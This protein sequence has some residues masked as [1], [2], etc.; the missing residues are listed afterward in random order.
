MR[1]EKRD[2][3][4][5]VGAV[6]SDDIKCMNMT[7]K[8]LA[9]Q[10]GIPKSLISEIISG[11]RKMSKDVAI[12]LEPVFGVPAEYWL[13]IQNEYEIAKKKNGMNLVGATKTIKTGTKHALDIAHWLI[14]R[15]A[16]DAEFTGEY[17]THLKLQKL[18][19]LVQ[20][21]SIRRRGE[22]IFIEP[23]VHW[24]YGPVV[25]RVYN[26]YR[27]Y[28]RKPIESAPVISFDTETERLLDKVYK[29][30][31]GYSAMGL[32]TITHGKTSW[33]NTQQNEEMT[34]EMISLDD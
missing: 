34:L 6:L 1:N 26:A 31:E 25:Q 23:I 4:V 20:R 8:A 7:Q 18:L 5:S 24:E 15:A 2:Y 32:V 21:E 12:K 27:D 33:K 17:I 28:N 30:F 11:K 3:A 10:T 29:Q 13:N 14:N 22:A 16:K 9:E 19:Y